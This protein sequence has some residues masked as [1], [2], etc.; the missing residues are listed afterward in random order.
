MKIKSFMSMAFA[1]VLLGG[2]VTL[3]HAHEVSSNQI[4]P[5][6]DSEAP[7]GHAESFD[8]ESAEPLEDG[9]SEVQILIKAAK[10]LALATSNAVCG[11]TIDNI[12]DAFDCMELVQAHVAADPQNHDNLDES[13]KAACYSGCGQAACGV[14]HI[15]ERCMKLC[16]PY[17]GKMS[18]T[19]FKLIDRNP[20]YKCI[21]CSAKAV[22]GDQCPGNPDVTEPCD[23]GCTPICKDASCNEKGFPTCHGKGA[24]CTPPNVANLWEPPSKSIREHFLALIKD[25]STCRG[26]ALQ[27]NDCFKDMDETQ[28]DNLPKYPNGN[29]NYSS[30]ATAFQKCVDEVDPISGIEM[31]NFNS[32]LTVRCNRWSCKLYPD[33]R[34]ACAALANITRR[35]DFVKACKGE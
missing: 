26:Y 21:H 16:C 30:V 18:G 15:R 34:K 2:I 9:G 31:D 25:E 3:A 4:N 24:N 19:L 28:F 12:D 8:S 20:I 23:V 1:M 14:T 13:L 5:V 6:R 17:K 22:I 10:L 35:D 32:T 33:L 7:Y 11:K 27:L 29:V